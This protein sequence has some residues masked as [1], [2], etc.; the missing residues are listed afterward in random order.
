MEHR[1]LA[2]ELGFNKR[3]IEFDIENFITHKSW[4]KYLTSWGPSGES[5]QRS[6]VEAGKP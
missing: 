3:T 5:R 2:K 1:V 4:R 6:R